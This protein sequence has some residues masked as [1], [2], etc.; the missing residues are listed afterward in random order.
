MADPP[1]PADL[2]RVEV[3]LTM[4]EDTWKEVEPQLDRLVREYDLDTRVVRKVA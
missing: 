1:P 2:P 4:T 3:T